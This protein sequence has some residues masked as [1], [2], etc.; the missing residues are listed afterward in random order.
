M[1]LTSGSAIAVFHSVPA[2]A[3]PSTGIKLGPCTLSKIMQR[4]IT[5]WDH[6][7]ILADN[8]SLSVP[9]VR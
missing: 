6:A 9:E 1:G 8:P 7:D 2:I 3:H 4:T 5:T